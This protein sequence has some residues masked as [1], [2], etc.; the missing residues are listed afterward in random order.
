MDTDPQTPQDDL[1]DLLASLGETEA[2][3]ALLGLEPQTPAVSPEVTTSNAREDVSRTPDPIALEPEGSAAGAA[4][5]PLRNIYGLPLAELLYRL[6]WDSSSDGTNAPS[7][8][9]G[10]QTTVTTPSGQVTGGV[11]Q[12]LRSVPWTGELSAPV[13]EPHAEATPAEPTSE[14]PPSPNA[15]TESTSFDGIDW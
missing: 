1:D 14:L 9:R 2:I 8:T 6:P 7:V 12:F 3:D 11:E 5:E 13:Q 15:P 4:E 10:Q